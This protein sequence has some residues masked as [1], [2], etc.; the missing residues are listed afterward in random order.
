MLIITF[1]LTHLPA[2]ENRSAKEAKGLQVGVEAP[3]FKAVDAN[4]QLFDLEKALLDG[5]V[6]L[7]FYRGQWCPFCNRH[8]SQLQDSLQLIADK[9]ASI[10]AISPEKPEYLEKMEEKTGATFT[11]LYDEGY[12]IAT[13]YGVSFFPKKT[14][15]AMYNTILGANIKQAHQSDAPEL[16]IPATYIIGTDGEVKWRQFDPDYKKRSTVKD[17]VENL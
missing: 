14:E 5:P 8:L 16:P 6:V 15:L 10:V 17:I 7:I 9:G 3:V 12:K 13:A 1:A 11:L 2:Q 4:N